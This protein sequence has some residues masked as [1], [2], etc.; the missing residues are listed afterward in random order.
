[1]RLWTIEPI[2]WSFLHTHLILPVGFHEV[3]RHLQM[4]YLVK[5]FESS[6]NCF[7]KLEQKQFLLKSIFLLLWKMH[8]EMLF[9]NV[10]RTLIVAQNYFLYW[11]AKHK[12]FVLF[13]Q[14][15]WFGKFEFAW[16]PGI[17]DTLHQYYVCLAVSNLCWLSFHIEVVFT[18]SELENNVKVKAVKK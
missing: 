18:S 17:L 16:V 12:I 14:S 2:R 8:L 13:S 11:T 5:Y 15:R 4:R 3:K 10:A 9:K 6:K 1:M 7:Q